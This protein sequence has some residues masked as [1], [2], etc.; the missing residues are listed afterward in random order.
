MDTILNPRR[1]YNISMYIFAGLLI[2]F[3]EDAIDKE[4]FTSYPLLACLIL[5]FILYVKP[6][7][8]S[9]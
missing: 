2:I 9:E 3:G 6:K 7:K 5:V 8:R 4:F 1:S